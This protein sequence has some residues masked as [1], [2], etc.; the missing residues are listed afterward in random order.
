[1]KFFRDC[2]T[3]VDGKTWDLARVLWGSGVAVT[4][5][6]AIAEVSAMYLRL[7]GYPAALPLWGPDGWTMWAGAFGVAMAA[8]AA[9]VW[10]KRSTEPSVSVTSTQDDGDGNT[11]KV[12]AKS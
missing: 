1:M 7:F 12:E 2:F 3:G 6:P 8:S 5:Q 10:V 11:A 4:M 9:S